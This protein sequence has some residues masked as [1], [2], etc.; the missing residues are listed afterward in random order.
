MSGSGDAPAE[1][2]SDEPVCG[3]DDAVACGSDDAVVL[4]FNDGDVRGYGD[5]VGLAAAAVA[6]GAPPALRAS[7]RLGASPPVLFRAVI[8]DFAMTDSRH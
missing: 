5:T 7:W 1:G 8:L 6:I 2:S 3:S 4:S